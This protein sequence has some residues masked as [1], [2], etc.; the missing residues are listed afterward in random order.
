MVD[1]FYGFISI[2]L[3]YSGFSAYQARATLA[4]VWDSKNLPM[5]ETAVL[6]GAAT[7]FFSGI[8]ILIPQT[9]TFGLLLFNIFL[10][11]SL[12][13]IHQF[14]RKDELTP[15]L[16]NIGYFGFVS[17]ALASTNFE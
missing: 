14:W 10:F 6:L 1:I 16:T 9:R 5:G 17:I 12:F 15:A 13:T 8:C 3:M 4:Q 11:I 7:V 2:W